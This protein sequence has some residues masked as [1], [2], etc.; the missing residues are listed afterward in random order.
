ML[1]L[2]EDQLKR[3]PIKHARRPRPVR[4][5][6]DFFSF[7]L[8][9]VRQMV[10]CNGPRERLWLRFQSFLCSAGVERDF[11]HL[12]LTGSFVSKCEH[13]RSV[14]AILQTRVRYGAPAY[15]AL[16][17]FFAFGMGEI[18]SQFSTRLRFWIPGAP[19]GLEQIGRRNPRGFPA[20][21]AFVRIKLE[22]RPRAGT[23]MKSRRGP[24]WENLFPSALEF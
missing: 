7:S 16:A 13:P 18:R 19:P 17:P 5:T 4:P 24:G 10:C 6:A 22:Q 3:T 1:Y 2:E 15:A 9:E 21:R 20:S 8:E 11:S 23:R 12:Y 14:E